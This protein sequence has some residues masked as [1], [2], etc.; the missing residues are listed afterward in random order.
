M[1]KEVFASKIF[2]LQPH[3]LAQIVQQPALEEPLCILRVRIEDLMY[4]ILLDSLLSKVNGSFPES[5]TYH[6]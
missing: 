4:I 6:A 3:L 2:E 5:A 1:S